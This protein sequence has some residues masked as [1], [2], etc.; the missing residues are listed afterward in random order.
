ALLIGSCNAAMDR[1]ELHDLVAIWDEPGWPNSSGCV[2]CPMYG[3][4]AGRTG[5]TGAPSRA[6][7]GR[8]HRARPDPRAG[9]TAEGQRRAVE[10]HLEGTGRLRHRQLW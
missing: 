2:V 1:D 6:G 8:S 3:N 10:W 5:T 4:A 7:V 9:V